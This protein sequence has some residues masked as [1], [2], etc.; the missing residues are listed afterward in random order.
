MGM[1]FEQLK[2]SFGEREELCK[3]SDRHSSIEKAVNKIF[4]GV[5]HGICIYHLLNNLKYNFKKSDN[6]NMN[7]FFGQ[8]QHKKKKDSIIT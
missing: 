4:L 8:Q 5:A 7:A 2:S 1:V 3:I 6:T